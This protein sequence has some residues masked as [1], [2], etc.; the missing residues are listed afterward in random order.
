M[1]LQTIQDKPK[2][3]VIIAGEASGDAHAARLVNE[4]KKLEV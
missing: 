2:N 3:A 1:S 4:L